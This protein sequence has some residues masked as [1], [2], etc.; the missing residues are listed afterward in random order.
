MSNTTLPTI[1]LG[2]PN[3]PT[4]FPIGT[5]VYF[6]VLNPNTREFFISKSTIVQITIIDFYPFVKY[7]V[8]GEETEFVNSHLF[9]TREDVINNIKEQLNYLESN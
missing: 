1:E 5:L 8:K 7:R 9:L 3:N 6:L 2:I 4:I